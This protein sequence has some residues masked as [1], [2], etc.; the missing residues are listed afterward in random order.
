MN[1]LADV[2]IANFSMSLNYGESSQIEVECSMAPFQS[3]PIP[4]AEALQASLF[5]LN[6]SFLNNIY[7]L[8]VPVEYDMSSNPFFQVIKQCREEKQSNMEV[9][10]RDASSDSIPTD[11]HEHHLTDDWVVED[12]C[13]TFPKSWKTTITANHSHFAPSSGKEDGKEDIPSDN[14][15]IP[16]K[17]SLNQLKPLQSKETNQSLYNSLLL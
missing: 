8:L 3:L 12:L 16:E 10:I 5:R 17:P 2:S 13:S 7:D 14:P 15:L 6:R 9:E 4:L 1:T 11:L